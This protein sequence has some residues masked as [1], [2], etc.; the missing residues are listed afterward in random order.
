M[1]T[2]SSRADAQRCASL[3]QVVAAT[4]EALGQE[5]TPMAA[6]LMATDLADYPD[7]LI[8]DALKACRRELTGRL[9]LA[10]IIQR[11]DAADG[12]PGRDEAWAIALSG[13]DE[14]DTVVVTDEI[15][16]AMAAA[17][18]V[19][20]AGD[21]VGARMAFLS[22]YDRLVADARREK[23]PANW[24]VSLGFD[25]VRRV[26]AVEQALRLG[27]LTSDAA[28]R[29]LARIEAPMTQDGQ[30]I[31]GLLTGKATQP[32]EA[33]RGK[34]R[35]LG[36]MVR[37]EAEARQSAREEAERAERERFEVAKAEAVAAVKSIGGAV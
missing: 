30:A 20:A 10:A 5:I 16:Q 7:R 17:Q 23:R 22:A 27:R 2:R 32:S 14:F 9:T 33:L 11:I 21:K 6:E 28:H 37:R 13:T 8:A 3:A 12:R 35:E 15:G 29:E 25:P 34:W 19:L 36:D 18:P 31:A 26:Q 4:A 24:S 1:T